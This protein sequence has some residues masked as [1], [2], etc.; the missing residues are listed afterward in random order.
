MFRIK[1]IKLNNQNPIL[2]NNNF[3]FI[4]GK[5]DVGKTVLVKTID[6]IL[7]SSH[8]KIEELPG[9]EN[10]SIV[11]GIIEYGKSKTLYLRRTAEGDYYYRNNSDDPFILVNREIYIDQIQMTFSSLDRQTFESYLQIVEESLSYRGI[12]YMNFIDQYSLGNTLNIIPQSNEIQFYKRVNAQTLFFF[13]KE[14]QESLN[15]Y[16][17]ELKSLN[18]RISEYE[19]AKSK[20]EFA[21]NGLHEEFKNLSL[22]ESKDLEQMKATFNEYRH[23]V[24]RKTGRSINGEKELIYLAN[25]SAKI[26]SQI[27][28][29]QRLEKQTALISNRND[30][31]HSVLSFFKSIIGKEEKLRTYYE[32][33]EHVLEE[34]S[35]REAIVSTKDYCKT[36]RKLQTEKRIIDEKISIIQKDLTEKSYLDISKSIAN[37]ESYLTSCSDFPLHEYEGLVSRRKDIQRKIEILNKQAR[38]LNTESLTE[39]INETYYSMPE[40]VRYV[41]EDKKRG[42]HIQY[43]P[44]TRS[45]MGEENSKSLSYSPGSKARKSCWQVIAYICIQSFIKEEYPGFPIL[46]LLIIDGFNE[47]FDDENNNLELICSFFG[48]LCKEKGIQLIVTSSRKMNQIDDC[49][50]VNVSEGVNKEYKNCSI[51]KN[52]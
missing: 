27:A 47:P 31:I 36:I 9:L 28:I 42:V 17:R 19:F 10:I 44:M 32:C 51:I 2:L 12:S 16:K 52:L 20:Y 11:D 4:Y 38:R 49:L 37:I 14:T 33:I 43:S 46:P 41:R 35:T 40:D 24:Y 34:I 26:E 1:E 7:G 22:P 48:N 3:V 13:D 18:D 39:E 50:F 29:E 23:N 6:F 25:A 30:K 21:I 8:V 45:L 15:A 5:N